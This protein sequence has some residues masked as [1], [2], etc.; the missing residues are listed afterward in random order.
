MTPVMPRPAKPPMPSVDELQ[1]AFIA[2][3]R[4]L[5]PLEDDDRERILHAA[6][7]FLGV[8]LPTNEAK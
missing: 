7:I 5:H 6:A 8:Y 2:C 4:A 3:V 1:T